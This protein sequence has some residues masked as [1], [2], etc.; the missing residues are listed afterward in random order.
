MLINGIFQ[1]P[2][3]F[4]NPD[5]NFNIT[6]N[7]SAG[8][9]TINFTGLTVD[10]E[11]VI[12]D[13]DVNQ[14]QL[15]RGGVIVSL[16]STPGLGFAP[17]AGAKIRP[18]VSSGGTITSIVGVATTGASLGII[19]AFYNNTT[20]LLTVTTQT[21]PDWVFGEQSQDE[22]QLNSLPFCGGLSIGGTFSVVSV[23]AT[24]TFGVN[25]G[26]RETTHN[27]QGGGEA[28]PWFGDLTFGA[29]YNGI[30]GIG[31][32]VVDLGYEHRFV[33]ANTG[34]INRSS[35]VSYTHLTLPTNREV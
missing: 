19:T 27:Y 16:G 14:N 32:T 31:V 4:N 25:I 7:A 12:S 24:N 33:S 18:V 34:A 26:V 23:A 2:S 20:G 17:L 3:T 6:E 35:A 21:D 30:N 13:E 28:L 1:N 15:P 11:L 29:G 10:N 22:V 5:G 8:I 9:T